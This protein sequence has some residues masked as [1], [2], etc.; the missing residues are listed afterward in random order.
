MR[1]LDQLQAT[2]L[3]G[4]DDADSPFFSPDGQW[5]GF[6]ADGKLKKIAVTGGAAVT[7]CDA[8][9]GRGGAWSEDGTIVFSP[10][11]TPGTRL[12]RVSSAGGTPEPLTSLAERETSRERWPQVLPGGKAVLFTSSSVGDYNDANLVV[13]RAADR[14]A[15][16]RAARRLSRPVSAERPSGLHPRRDALCG[17]LR[18]R[19][20]G[21]DGSPVPVL[22]GVSSNA[23][24]GRRAVRCV[25]Q[26]HAGVS[27]GAEHRAAD[28][29][30]TGWITRGR[31]TP[32]R[33]TLANWSNLQFA[34]DG[35]PSRLADLWTDN[36]TSGS[37]SGRATRL[38][39]LTSD[40]AHDAKPVWTP[41]G[42]RIVFAS[43]RGGQSDA[44][45]CTGSGPMGPATRERLTESKNPQQPASWHPSGK[46]LAF[47]EVNPTTS[48]DLMILPMEGD[49]ASGWKP[50]TAHRVLE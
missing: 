20:A 12:L 39:R 17:A 14:R 31:R 3:S 10:D 15:Q 21:G 25:G 33:A 45:T 24:N 9:N 1:R 46:F 44:R 6:F 28:A 5:I 23:G 29:R 38:T 48:W 34:P 27:A 13:Q 36:L 11:A 32:L 2:P 43:A 30:S 35:R 47:D 49:E 7:L 50:G 37:T 16:G 8:P 42:R 26:R 22:E 41:D 4:T 18:S 40:P 19:P